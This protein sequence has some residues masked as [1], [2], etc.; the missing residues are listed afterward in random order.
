MTPELSLHAPSPLLPSPLLVVEDE[1]VMHER[2]H[3][4][5]IGLGYEATAVSFAGSLLEARDQLSN[6]PFAIVLVDIGLP[7]GNGV[8]L[9]RELRWQDAA[10]PIIV[11]STWST[12][13]VILEAL[14]AGAIGYLLKERDDI[15]I[16]LSIRSSLRGGAPID[17]FIAK[18]ILALV[19]TLALPAGPVPFGKGP[20]LTA[21]EIE[22]LRMVAKGLTNKEISNVLS[23]SRFTVECH[24][25]NTYK[26]LAVGSRTEAVFEARIHGLL[27]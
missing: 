27:P 13:Q 19:N 4:I 9:I 2:L 22:I 14:Q 21:R 24:I 17:P 23:L 12:D 5:L 7:D 25:K 16:S 15:E 18:R 1:P 3:A 10:L 20:P 8:D 26:K 11:I 6:Q